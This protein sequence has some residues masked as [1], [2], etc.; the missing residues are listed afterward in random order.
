LVSHIDKSFVD[1]FAGAVENSCAP[2]GV[3]AIYDHVLS[4]LQANDHAS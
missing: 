3:R 4:V 2:K 1:H